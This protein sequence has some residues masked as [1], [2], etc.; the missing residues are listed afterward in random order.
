MSIHR[1]DAKLRGIPRHL[2]SLEKWAEGADR[3]H[4]QPYEQHLPYWHCKIPVLDRLL[5]PP[6]TSP[7]LQGQVICLL[8]RA[9]TK[10]AAQGQASEWPYYRVAVLLTLPYLFQSEVTVFFAESYYRGFY[11]Q[12]HLLPDSEKPS[13]RFAFDLP[14]GFVE[15]GTLVEWESET[16]EGEIMKCSEQWWTLGHPL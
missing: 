3:W 12:Q 7:K 4:P 16:A 11:H 10:L 8:L 9:A 1:P 15:L 5:E 14:P 6:T 2:R 13:K